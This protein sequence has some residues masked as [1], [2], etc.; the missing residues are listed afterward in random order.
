MKLKWEGEAIPLSP[1][2]LAIAAAGDAADEEN[3]AAREAAGSTAEA[4]P[5]PHSPPVSPIREPQHRR[6]SLRQNGDHTPEPV[7][8]PT[9]S[10]QTF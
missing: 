7:S 1:P 4:H 10:A 8:P 6:G 5:K 9:P 2:M 3:A